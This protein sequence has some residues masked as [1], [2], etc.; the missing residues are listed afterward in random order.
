[1]TEALDACKK[2]PVHFESFNAKP[3]VPIQE[4]YWDFGDNATGQSASIQHAYQQGG[5]YNIQVYA[6][7]DNGCLS[8]TL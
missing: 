8:D 3:T 1:M 6:M 5:E 2:E 4:W 7:A